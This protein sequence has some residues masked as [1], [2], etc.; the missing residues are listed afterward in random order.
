M[1][2]APCVS[3]HIPSFL[4]LSP[5]AEVTAMKSLGH[6][7]RVVQVSEVSSHSVF[8]RTERGH[9]GSV[10]F[11]PEVIAHSV[12][13]HPERTNVLRYHFAG[14]EHARVELCAP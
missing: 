3:V 14:A 8:L 9:S 12:R 10:V 4:S 2:T 6:D 1:Q 5:P 13:S 11:V 7:V